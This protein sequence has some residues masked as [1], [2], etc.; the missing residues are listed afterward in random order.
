MKTDNKLMK[1]MVTTEKNNIK[2]CPFPVQL[3]SMSTQS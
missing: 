3:N 2:I 1:N